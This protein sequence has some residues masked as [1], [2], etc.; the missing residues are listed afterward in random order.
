MGTPDSFEVLKHLRALEDADPK[1]RGRAIVTLGK[2]HHD[3]RVIEML[4]LKAQTDTDPR[5]RDLAAKVVGQ[6]RA[7]AGTAASADPFASGTPQVRKPRKPS[8]PKSALPPWRCTYCDTEGNTSQTCPNCGAER[9]Y[10][11][12]PTI[13]PLAP[14]APPPAGTM[15]GPRWTYDDVPFLY[16]TYHRDFL[17]SRKNHLNTTRGYS[18]FLVILAVILVGVLVVSALVVIPGWRDTQTLEANGVV[19]LGTVEDHEISESDDSGDTYYLTYSFWVNGTDRYQKE[20]R[21]NY[22]TY[23]YYP[24]GGEIEVRYLPANP[25]NSELAHDDS[26]HNARRNRVIIA[27]VVLVVSGIVGVFAMEMRGREQRLAKQGRVLRGEVLECSAHEDS[28]DDLQV[29]LRYR[30]VTPQGREIIKRD[31]RQ[32]NHLKGERLPRPGD[33]VAVLYVSDKHFRML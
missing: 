21:V 33:P 26:E 15:K 19:T 12:S 25:A 27:I 2:L 18:C 3:P 14:D 5:V 23:S 9:H 13:Q 4:A 17:L 24:I 16:N 11:G 28:D 20:V 31:N 32:A 1:T 22:T 29:R 7:Q 30:F 10:S 8:P 6:M